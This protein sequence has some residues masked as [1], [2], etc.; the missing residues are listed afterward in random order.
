[1]PAPTPPTKKQIQS[2]FRASLAQRELAKRNLFDFV[3][4][5]FM[6]EGRP[7]A[8]NWHHGLLCEIGEALFHRTETRVIINIPP[9]FLKS[10]TFSQCLQA[11]MIGQDP[12][13]RSSMLSASYSANLAERD[14]GLT[15]EIIESDWY[16]QLFPGI[17]IQHDM[18]SKSEWQVTAG[19]KRSSAGVGGTLTG[20]GGDHLLIDDPIKPQDANSDAVRSTANSWTGE[21]MR[22]R[23]DDPAKGTICFIMQRLHE[24][25]PAGYLMDKMKNPDADQYTIVCMENECARRKMYSFGKFTYLREPGELLH[26]ARLDQKQ[27]KA[28]KV[29][30]GPNYEGQYNQRPTKMEGDYFKLKWINEHDKD[31]KEIAAEHLN[32]VYQAWDLAVTSKETSKDDPDYSVCATVGVDELGRYWLVDIWRGQV[33]AGE[34]AEEIIN[35]HKKWQPKQVWIEK[36]A[37]EKSVGATVKLRQNQLGYYFMIEPVSHGNQDK[38]FRARGIQGIMSMGNFYVPG[39]ATWLPDFK[40][41]LAGFPKGK[42]DDQ[43]DAIAYLGQKI[44]SVRVGPMHKRPRVLKAYNPQH[45]DAEQLKAVMEEANRSTHTQTRSRKAHLW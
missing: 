38:E 29:A 8:A 24:L 9:R 20:K 15:K 37:I 26:P 10:E 19:A 21:T 23:L 3:K 41:E 40:I 43:V 44:E 11:W 28:M 36:G 22:S 7:F 32:Y 2:K 12:S 14:A 1:M 18:R 16:Q 42:H 33:D 17:R 31:G 45:I 25:D 27:T 4:Y 35:Q 13:S 34:L 39:K 5:R 6:A 30:M